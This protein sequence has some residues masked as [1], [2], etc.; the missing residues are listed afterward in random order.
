MIEMVFKPG[1]PQRI[2]YR[3]KS[4]GKR[5][6]TCRRCRPQWAER[7]RAT[8]TGRPRTPEQVANMRHARWGV[9]LP[10]SPPPVTPPS[11]PAVDR[12]G[13]PLPA[14]IVSHVFPRAQGRDSAHGYYASGECWVTVEGSGEEVLAQAARKLEVKRG[15]RVALEFSRDRSELVAVV[16]VLRQ[17]V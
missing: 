1:E 12:F 6:A 16:A 17:A 14:G 10:P 15:D 5:H 13:Q 7:I 9:P 3:V 2:T 8:M 4:C 11:R